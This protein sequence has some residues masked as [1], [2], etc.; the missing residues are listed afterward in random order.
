MASIQDLS[1]YNEVIE[2]EQTD[3]RTEYVEPITS[4]TYKYTFPS[5]RQHS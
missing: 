4:N 1:N 3:I 2:E 5:G